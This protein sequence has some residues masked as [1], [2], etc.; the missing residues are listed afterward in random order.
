MGHFILS[1]AVVG[2]GIGT[3]HAAMNP[4][5]VSELR[6]TNVPSIVGIINGRLSFFKGDVSMHHLR[7]FVRNLFPSNTV[8]QVLDLIRFKHYGFYTCWIMF[9][10]SSKW[11][12]CV[13]MTKHLHQMHFINIVQLLIK[14]RH[15]LI[16]SANIC[17]SPILLAIQ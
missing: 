2:I 5:M 9:S 4:A 12:H 8:T 15:I 14:V 11:N 6:L 13:T 1:S 16:F 7:D 17:T 3:V 10:E